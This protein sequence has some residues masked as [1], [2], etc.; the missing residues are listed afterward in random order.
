MPE[1]IEAFLDRTP[2]FTLR[3]L[4][5]VL[6]KSAGKNSKSRVY[7]LVKNRRRSGRLGVVKEGVYYV[8]RPGQTTSTAPVDSF[9][10]ASRLVPEAVLAFHTALDILGFGHSL[11]HTH[12]YFAKTYRRP[13]RFRGEQFRS[14][15]VPQQLVR[16]GRELF[17]TEKVERLGVKIL[18]TGK[19]RSLVEALEH[20]EYCGGFEEMYRCLEKMPYLRPEIVLQYL[21]LRQQKNLFARVG[22]FL[23]QH[24]E[25]FHIEESLLQSLERN[26][27]AQPLYWDRSRKGGL[28]IK[29][30]NLIVPQAVAGRS[31]EE[32]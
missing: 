14:V 26:K 21:D 30:W 12:Y 9:L 31:W 7:N 24:R 8:V 18:T 22:F 15:K 28:L 6:G 1:T 16:A 11:F 32:F 2:V 4:K 19:E 5:M 29:R 13:F 3:D 20:P 10:A 17:G 27:P 23:E 25:D